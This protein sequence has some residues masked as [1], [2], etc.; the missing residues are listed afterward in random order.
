MPLEK[1]SLVLIDLIAKVKDTD[2]IFDTTIEE[3]A[4]KADVFDPAHNYEPRLVSVGEGW[5]IKGLDEALTNASSGDKFNI[6]IAPAKGFG[7]REPS[8]IRMIPQRKLGEKANEIKVGDV[9]DIND[10]TGM[11]RFIGSGRVQVDFNH[12]FAG[13]TLSYDINIVKKL[14]SNDDK[15]IPLIKR[16]LTLD[17]KNIRPSLEG[18][19]LQIELPEESFLIEGL[20]VIKR[21]IA[22]DAFK[23][24]EGIKH[25]RFIETYSLQ[26]TST[27]RSTDDLQEKGDEPRSSVTPEAQQLEST[28]R[29]QG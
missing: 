16:R 19:V 14:E 9:I 13:R 1:G 8:K 23:F 5:V 20:Q 11:V 21:A 27:R 2:K 7:E 6:D 4:K 15:I 10:R 29:Q 25:V 22:N 18:E 28:T 3:A 17:T 12:R 24:L 26:S